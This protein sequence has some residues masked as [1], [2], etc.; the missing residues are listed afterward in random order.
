MKNILA[1]IFGNKKERTDFLISIFVILIFMGSIVYYVFRQGNTLLSY[2]QTAIEIVDSKDDVLVKKKLDELAQLVNV[3]EKLEVAESDSKSIF[4]KFKKEKATA[5]AV[6]ISPSSS[7]E[8][9]EEVKEE[10][11]PEVEAI[12]EL[13]PEAEVIEEEA[14]TEFEDSNSAESAEEIQEE[15]TSGDSL[16]KEDIEAFKNEEAEESED[17]VTA[18]PKEYNISPSDNKIRDDKNEQSNISEENNYGCIVIVGAFK[19]R[20]NADNLQVL[21]KNKAYPVYRGINKG[22]FVVGVNTSC[23]KKLSIPLLNKLKKEFNTGAWIYK[24]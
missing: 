9:E 7:T 16:S 12:P 20:K 21:I 8:I 5:A 4:D 23:D 22:Y 10:M 6:T 2:G 1:E 3:D 15:M 18:D 14:T 17:T 19:E 11:T 24:R 13:T